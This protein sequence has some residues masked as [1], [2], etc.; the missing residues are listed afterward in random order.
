MGNLNKR[1]VSCII[2]FFQCVLVEVK[3]TVIVLHTIENS[4]KLE[5]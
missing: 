2:L 4:C 3:A 1:Q 5:S